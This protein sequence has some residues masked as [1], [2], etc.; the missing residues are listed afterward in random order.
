MSFRIE[1]KLAIDHNQLIDFKTF[2]ANKTVKQIYQRRKIES[3]YFDN[4]NYEMYYDSLEG[5]VPRKKIRIRNYPGSDDN[6]LYLEIK[7]SSVEGR[8]KTR[9]I[10]DSNKFNY[11]KT[12][13]ISDSQYGLC[14]PCLYVVY[15]RDYFK[16]G[17]VRISIDNNISY[18]LY[19][20]NIYHKDESSI[21][22]I[23]T[24]VRKNLDKLMEDFPFQKKRYSKYCNAVEKII[25]K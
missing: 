13:G 12:N 20:K 3:L 11:I 5:L 14:K 17:D 21:V 2:L 8:F 23:K 19:T 1:E 7:I 22:E 16:M 15:D 4:R 25:F 10:I 18:R 6:S 9:K 24:S